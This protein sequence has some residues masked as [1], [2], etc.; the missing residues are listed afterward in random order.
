MECNTVQM[1]SYSLPWSRWGRPTFWFWI[2]RKKVSKG[3]KRATEAHWRLGNVDFVSCVESI[4]WLK[5]SMQNN[6]LIWL[7]VWQLSWVWPIQK[8]R[9]RKMVYR[10]RQPPISPRM[11]D[12]RHVRRQCWIQCYD[13]R[14]YQLCIY[15]GRSL[16]EAWTKVGH[17]REENI[18]SQIR[19]VRKL[20]NFFVIRI[21]G[22]VNGWWWWTYLC[23]M[24]AVS[25]CREKINPFSLLNGKCHLHWISLR[26]CLWYWAKKGKTVA[27]T[28]LTNRLL[29]KTK[30]GMRIQILSKF[31]NS[32]QTIN[33]SWYGSPQSVIEYV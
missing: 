6:V 28:N 16:F 25:P 27:G 13:L 30:N 9:K 26:P 20:L 12:S 1:I 29:R 3:T 2:C 4:S 33:W 14:K 32:H 17:T 21:F 10:C 31:E 23:T 7:T 22:A 11:T 24:S 15:F 5:L 8:R 19:N 18:R